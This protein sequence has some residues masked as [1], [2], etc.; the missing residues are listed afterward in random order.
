MKKNVPK[1]PPYP[2]AL[3]EICKALK[4]HNHFLLSCHVLPEGDAIGSILALDSMLRRMGKKTTVVAED[5]FPQRL[6]CLSS[7]RWTR[8]DKLTKP[9]SAYKAIVL[10]DCPTLERIGKVKNMITKDTVIF[11]IDHHVSNSFFGHYNCV[12]PEAAASGEVVFDMFKQLRM[13]LTKEEAS[14]LYVALST[15]TGSFK[16]GNTTAQTHRIVSELLNAGVD[17]E[18]VNQDLYDTYSINK[19]SLYSRLLGRVRTTASGRVAWVLMHRQD[20]MDSGAIDEDIEGF[21]D[22]LKSIR[23]VNIAFVLNELPLDG[24]VRGSFRS[25]NP[26]DVNKIATALHGGGHKKASGCTLRMNL[27]E[28]EDKVLQ[29]IEKIYPELSS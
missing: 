5:D 11:N 16:Y 21:I 6:Y 24:A 22:F 27:K 23:E 20:L 10:A 19:L 14:N 15:D 3:A 8:V 25:K 26:Y 7:K 28:A 17:I 29:Q 13:K 12:K 9:A 2:K 18:K 4:N 1:G